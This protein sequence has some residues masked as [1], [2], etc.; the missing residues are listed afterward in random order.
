MRVALYCILGEIDK[1]LLLLRLPVII[2]VVCFIR[3]CFHS[4]FIEPSSLKNGGKCGTPMKIFPW[5]G[6]DPI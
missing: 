3:F 5:V 6:A 4:A 1:M 2:R